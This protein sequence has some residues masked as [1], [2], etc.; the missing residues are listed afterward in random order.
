[1]EGYR[2]MCGQTYYWSTVFR[3]G[4]GVDESSSGFFFSAAVSEAV[5]EGSFLLLEAV[6]FVGEAIVR[7]CISLDGDLEGDLEEADF[8]GD[9]PGWR[10][11]EASPFTGDGVSGVLRFGIGET[12]NNTW[13]GKKNGLGIYFSLFLGRARDIRGDLL[14]RTAGRCNKSLKKPR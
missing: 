13:Y 4:A 7:F 10:E 12:T 11:A 8:E 2:G 9:C 5:T 1:M 6:G 14:R 3:L